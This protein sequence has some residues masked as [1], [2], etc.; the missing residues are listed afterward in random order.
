M[1]IDKELLDM[2][3]EVLVDYFEYD[4]EGNTHNGFD[5]TPFIQDRYE[6]RV[7][8][9]LNKLLNDDGGLLVP[10]PTK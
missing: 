8:D 2:I 3:V 5:I 1:I 9:E 4:V 10:K 7:I 6:Q